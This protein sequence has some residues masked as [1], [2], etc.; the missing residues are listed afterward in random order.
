MVVSCSLIFKCFFTK[1]CFVSINIWTDNTDVYSV[2]SPSSIVFSLRDKRSFIT[3]S[4]SSLQLLPR[5][6]QTFP[7]GYWASQLHWTDL[8]DYGLNEAEWESSPWG[9]VL[10]GWKEVWM[11]FTGFVWSDGHWESAAQCVITMI[12]V[13]RGPDSLLDVMTPGFVWNNHQRRRE[14][15]TLKLSS[16]N[17]WTRHS[18]T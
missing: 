1:R 14:E 2:V 11:M 16:S 13:E 6:S 3:P 8:T 17:E 9:M 12:N 15:E 5:P 7:D 10:S 18:L 4:L